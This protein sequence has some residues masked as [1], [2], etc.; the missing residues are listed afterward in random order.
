MLTNYPGKKILL[1]HVWNYYNRNVGGR[2]KYF[3]FKGI[4]FL[5]HGKQ[6]AKKGPSANVFVI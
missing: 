1:S 6:L 2:G 3:N 4:N 5:R